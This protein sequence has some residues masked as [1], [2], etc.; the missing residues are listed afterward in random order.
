MVFPGHTYLLFDRLV[1][2]HNVL[3]WEH[4]IH[5]LILHMCLEAIELSTCEKHITAN[6]L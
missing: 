2:I 1:L 6:R 5:C 4:S 3:L